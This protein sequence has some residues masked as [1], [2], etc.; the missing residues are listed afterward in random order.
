[1]TLDPVPLRCEAVKLAY[2][3]QPRVAYIVT[4]TNDDIGGSA[5]P[6]ASGLMVAFDGMRIRLAVLPGLPAAL[7]AVRC[8]LAGGNSGA[9]IGQDLAG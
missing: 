1:M 8:V 9:Q 3:G 6:V 7:P 5:G 4:L 2:T